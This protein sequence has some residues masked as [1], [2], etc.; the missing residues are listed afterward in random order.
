MKLV[1]LD[2]FLVESFGSVFSFRKGEKYIYTIDGIDFQLDEQLLHKV[3]GVH[4]TV[5]TIRENFLKLEEYR[6]NQLNYLL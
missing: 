4:L 2:D 3:N 6:D 5:E 1:C